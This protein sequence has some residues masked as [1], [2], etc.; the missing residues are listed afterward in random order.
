[1]FQKE[2]LSSNLIVQHHIEQC[3]VNL[4]LAVI[5]DESKVTKLVQEPI[6]TGTSG[7]NH[8]SQCFLAHPWYRP[9]GTPILIIVGHQQ[10]QSCQSLLR[11]V[12]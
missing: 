4:H 10:E 2:Q 11:I 12:E 8:L 5:F 6:N 7:A 9:L 3:A 1:M